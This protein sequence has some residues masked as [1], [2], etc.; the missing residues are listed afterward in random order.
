M[1]FE[2]PYQNINNPKTE[3]KKIEVTKTTEIKVE[4]KTEA[5]TKE[6]EEKLEKTRQEVENVRDS[7]GRGIDEGIKE[8]VVMFKANELPTSDSC[9]GHI[10]ES[11]LRPPYIEARAPNKPERWEGVDKAIEEIQPLKISDNEKFH[12]EYDKIMQEFSKKPE[13]P[14]YRK[15]EEKNKELTKKA[16]GLLDEFYKERQVEPDVKLQIKEQVEE[17]PRIYSGGE[18]YKSVI[19]EPTKEITEDDKK[20]LFAKLEK[21]R[22]EMQEFTKFLKDK[23][24]GRSRVDQI[25]KFK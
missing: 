18:S 24:F 2:N 13:T 9:E 8:T 20:I 25:N 5:E 12:L 3:E 15:W 14:E 10:D 6:K 1:N 22:V 11:G 21:S 7:E 23:Y 4:T 19:E 16:K 17:N